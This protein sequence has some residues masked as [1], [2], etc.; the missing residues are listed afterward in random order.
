MARATVVFP[1]PEPPAIPM[2][3]GVFMGIASALLFF[4]LRLGHELR[5]VV[6]SARRADH[7]HQLLALVLELVRGRFTLQADEVLRLAHRWTRIPQLDQC[8]VP[9]AY[10][11]SGAPMDG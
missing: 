8:V 1:E 4:E 10:S 7:T 11:S 6:G 2:M 9:A 5:G 3:T